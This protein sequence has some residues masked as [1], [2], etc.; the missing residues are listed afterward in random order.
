MKKIFILLIFSFAGI[1]CNGQILKDLSRRI[2]NDATSKAEQK[3]SSNIDQGLDSLTKKRTNPKGKNKNGAT[4]TPVDSTNTKVQASQGDS[5]TSTQTAPAT[6]STTG[7]NTGNKNKPAVQPNPYSSNGSFITL[8]VFPT[9]VLIGN[10]VAVTGKSIK[11]K[12]FNQVV[13]TIT[14][15]NKVS[16]SK[17]IPMKEDGS[18]ST[19]WQPGGD[20]DYTIEVKSSDGKASQSEDVSAFDFKEM[21]SVTE[22]PKTEIKRAADNLDHDIDATIPKLST[23]DAS[24][25]NKEITKVKE[26]EN[27]YLQLLNDLDA[28]GKNFDVLEKSSGPLP[29]TVV[30]NFE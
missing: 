10:S 27:A 28:A 23:K 14:A 30:T 8:K 24:G 20:G 9:K 5:N 16:Q 2:V 21:D 11:Y 3:V 17:N 7:T 4:I 19:T 29:Q 6:A 15:E 1:F 26:K 25:L 22:A 18:F 12:N 13:M